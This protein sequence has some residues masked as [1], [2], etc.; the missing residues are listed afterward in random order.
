VHAPT[1]PFVA[2]RNGKGFDQL[3]AQSLGDL[4][5]AKAPYRERY[6]TF[7]DRSAPDFVIASGRETGIELLYERFQ[8]VDELEPSRY[9]VTTTVGWRVRPRWVLRRP[10]PLPR[11]RVLFDFDGS[12]EGWSLENL[13][14]TARP[15]RGQGHFWGSRRK[16]LNSFH[17]RLGDR[18]V[19]SAVSPEFT[20]DR[21]CLSLGVGG[22]AGPETRVELEVGGKRVHVASGLEHDALRSVDWDVGAYVGELARL[23]VVDATRERWGFITVDNVVLSDVCGRR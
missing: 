3:H 12:L 18:A 17:R 20:L 9:D 22:G 16:V 7:L 8:L 2:S 10:R 14:A 4:K 6:A 13:R 1:I 15:P 5:W 21:S 23:R 11:A 19:G